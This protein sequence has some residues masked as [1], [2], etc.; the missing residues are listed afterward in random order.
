MG[1][2]SSA[3]WTCPEGFQLFVDS[4]GQ[5]AN[6]KQKPYCCKSELDKKKM[7]WGWQLHGFQRLPAMLA[8]V[9]SMQL[10]TGP[11]GAE[12]LEMHGTA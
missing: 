8:E 9:I 1:I 7:F 5:N 11:A 6:D 2:R 12:C 3:A 4:F 10:S